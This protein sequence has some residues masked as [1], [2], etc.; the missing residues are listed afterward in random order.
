MKSFIFWM[1]AGI[2]LLSTTYAQPK[3]EA[4]E[5]VLISGNCEMCKKAIETAGTVKHEASVDWNQETGAATL[6]YNPSKTNTD[7]I[8]QRIA[9]A[10]YDNAQYL[11]PDEAYASLPECCQYNREF[12]TNTPATHAHTPHHTP[13]AT[14]TDHSTHQAA[15]DVSQHKKEG[16]FQAIF[17]HYFNLKDALVK[18]DGTLAASSAARFLDALGAVK[19]DGLTS[20]E[21]ETWMNGKES[22]MTVTERIAGTDDIARQRT[23]F[24]SLS[25]QVY[26]LM[27]A[28]GTAQ[29]VYYQ[30]CP[31]FNNSK[32]AHWL[33]LNQDIQNPYYGAQMLTCGNT[34]ETVK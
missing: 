32:G 10:G 31:M 3:Y 19:M 24:A 18:S 21:H 15:T 6:T 14:A 34:V 11:A 9:L 2:M 20:A 16:Q 5:T 17:N 23:H 22:I 33:S 7:E 13:Q 12:K 1:A 4:T 8:L 28:S 27:K 25:E 29:P 30:R 26:L